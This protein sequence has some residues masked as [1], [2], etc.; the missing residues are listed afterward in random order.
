MPQPTDTTVAFIG[1]GVMGYPMAGHLAKAGYRTRVY[2][3]TRK[4]A[5]AWVAE[6]PGEACASP[7]AA[8]LGA[9]VVL[10]CVG[11]DDDVRSVA[12]GEQGILGGLQRG[13]VL[14]DHT[15]ASAELARELDAAAGAGRGI[16]RCAGVRRTS[17]VRSA[18]S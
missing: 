17:S 12:Y 6:Y 5:D 1:L 9:D 10:M 7:A 2:N 3:R 11:N 16:S 18:A 8:V 13:C 4:R 15:T 14:V